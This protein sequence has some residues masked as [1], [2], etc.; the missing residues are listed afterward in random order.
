MR[1]ATGAS[2]AAV[3]EEHIYGSKN[4]MEGTVGRGGEGVFPGSLTQ[5]RTRRK[6]GWKDGNK[7]SAYR[8][9]RTA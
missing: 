7:G 5:E 9:L 8:A 6:N 4:E 3:G 1:W 2:V